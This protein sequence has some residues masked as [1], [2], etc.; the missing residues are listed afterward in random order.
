MLP[1]VARPPHDPF[2][3]TLDAVQ[4]WRSLLL[5]DVAIA[6]PERLLMLDQA[7][8]GRSL[9][10]PSGS[11]GGLVPPAN[12]AVSDGGDVLM[13][14]VAANQVKRFDACTCAFV[15][16]DGIGG[17][18][19]GPRQLNDARAIAFAGGNVVIA[20][21]GNARV[22][23]FSMRGLALRGTLD[24]PPTAN[25]QQPWSPVA[26]TGDE[27]G[28]VFVADPANGCVHRFGRHGAW[29]TAFRGLG[30]VRHVAIDCSSRLYV[31]IDGSPG[32]MVR[33][34]DGAAVDAVTSVQD[35]AHL[36]GRLPFRVDADGALDFGAP[37]GAFDQSGVALPN[38]AKAD[39]TGYK[40]SGVF[41]S[42]ALDSALYRCQWHRVVLCGEIPSGT[43]VTVSTYTSEVELP[44]DV[45]E[46]LPVEA[47]ETNQVARGVSGEWDCLI[48][49]GEGRFLWLRLELAGGPAA[50]PCLGRVRIEYPRISL[51]RYLPGVFGENPIGADFTDRFL[52]IFDTTFRSIEALID[53]QAS[54]FD[55]MSTPAVRGKGGEPDF[56][57]WLASWVGITLDGQWP[58]SKQRA[59]LAL[60]PKLYDLRGT[61]EGLRQLLLL[62]IG[63]KGAR[64]RC[65]PLGND[66]CTCDCATHGCEQSVARCCPT[67]PNCLPSRPP[68]EYDAPPLLLE[69][70]ELRRWLFVGSSR[71][72]DEAT[73]WGRRIVNRSQ[74]DAGAQADCSQ[75]ITSQDPYRDPFHVYASTFSVFVPACIGHN[76]QERRSL[77]H[78]LATESPAHTKY[79]IEYVAPR[80]R[81]GVQS[82]VGLDAV[83]G[84]YPSGVTVG[85]ATLGSSTIL[86]ELPDGLAPDGRPHP[87]MR[88]GSRS[89][90]GST[91]RLD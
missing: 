5:R 53:H 80:F 33:N 19:A 79:H 9:T 1:P 68:R 36:F 44:H 14:D 91:T 83:V 29:Q 22:S 11:L 31:V 51:R 81:I 42:A 35:I 41:V 4:G 90:I 27:W 76:V 78:L 54:L 85:D 48:R 65:T 28:R 58:E 38:G 18:G 30:A 25:L 23:I 37:C 71:L 13:L 66:P 10:E 49:S 57:S 12:V 75:L 61:R 88:I 87:S 43:R 8:G 59:F 82:I 70:F 74:L 72:G 17:T 32:V 15:V 26:V 89:Q 7:P 34:P 73:L 62:F 16:V 46:G 6:E 24:V 84:C 20:D 63:L 52:A 55:P 86:G 56:L 60:A 2:W 69:H 64:R 21:T 67:R 45:V 50:S 3:C 40:E 47:W 39:P 77:E